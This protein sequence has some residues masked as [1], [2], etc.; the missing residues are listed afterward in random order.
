LPQIYMIGET[1]RCGF[2]GFMASS[3]SDGAGK[4]GCSGL[5]LYPLGFCRK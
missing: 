1:W 5:G 4:I 3:A 2:A